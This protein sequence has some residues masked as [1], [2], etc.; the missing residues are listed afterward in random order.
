MIKLRKIESQLL[1]LYINP[2]TIIKENCKANH[3]RKPCICLKLE[4]LNKLKVIHKIDQITLYTTFNPLKWWQENGATKTV[5][6]ESYAVALKRNDSNF[7]STL[8]FI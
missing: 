4:I 2:Y 1:I 6:S 3:T 8:K 5:F 7:F